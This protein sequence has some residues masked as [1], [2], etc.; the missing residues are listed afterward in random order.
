MHINKYYE[1]PKILLV[2]TCVSVHQ[3]NFYE[4]VNMIKENFKLWTFEYRDTAHMWIHVV[5][6]YDMISFYQGIVVS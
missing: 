4:T 3:I 5:I 1:R 2:V 6:W